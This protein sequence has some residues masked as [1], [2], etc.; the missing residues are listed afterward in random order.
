MACHPHHPIQPTPGSHQ[1]SPRFDPHQNHGNLG[2]EHSWR[3]KHS[4]AEIDLLLFSESTISFGPDFTQLIKTDIVH[5]AFYGSPS[6]HRNSYD[7]LS[8]HQDIFAEKARKEILKKLD[9]WK[10]SQ[11]NV[12]VSMNVPDPDFHDFDGDQIEDYLGENQVW[13]V[14]DDEDDMQ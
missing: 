3:R 7:S 9:E 6:T 2:L 5:Q 10:E 13:V 1:K 4:P 14:Y 8:T 11:A 12:F